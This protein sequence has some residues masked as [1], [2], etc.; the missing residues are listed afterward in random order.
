MNNGRGAA[1]FC[2]MVHDNRIET[3]S[4]RVEET[5]MSTSSVRLLP[6]KNITGP[7]GVALSRY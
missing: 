2:K 3:P 4:H 7:F 6:H 5:Q 1:L